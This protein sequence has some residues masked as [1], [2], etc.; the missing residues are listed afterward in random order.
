MAPSSERHGGSWMGLALAGAAGA[1]WAV[2]GLMAT[3][4]WLHFQYMP[5]HGVV[6]KPALLD[7]SPSQEIFYYFAALVLTVVLG[8][9]IATLA[10]LLRHPITG[11]LFMLL[12]GIAA[13]IFVQTWCPTAAGGL[14][15]AVTRS[16]AAC[17]QLA[18]VLLII[19]FLGWP[20]RADPPAEPMRGF[21]PNRQPLGEIFAQWLSRIAPILLFVG[22]VL[23]AG[24]PLPMAALILTIPLAWALER[25][26]LPPPQPRQGANL[27]QWLEAAST[28]PRI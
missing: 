26:S 22:L 24:L 15:R 17:G 14:L 1:V 8:W 23:L 13:L 19:G 4:P 20:G 12:A 10:G 16:P 2:A 11:S 5:Y 27:T 28:A 25:V 6:A 18:L 9:A 7:Y 21:N 3:T